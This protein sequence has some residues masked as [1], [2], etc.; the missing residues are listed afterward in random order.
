MIR[1][2]LL[3]SFAGHSILLSHARGVR[4]MGYSHSV[5]SVVLHIALVPTLTGVHSAM[6]KNWPEKQSN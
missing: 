2:Y 3:V 1:Y 4:V 5:G 6:T